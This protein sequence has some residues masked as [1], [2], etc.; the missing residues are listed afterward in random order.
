MS[1]PLPAADSVIFDAGQL[2]IASEDDRVVTGLLLPYGVEGHTNIGGFT[3]DAGMIQLP[4]DPEV[5]TL[6]VEHDREQPVGRAVSIEER[7]DGV[8]ASY[9]IAKTPEGD[10]ALE[11]IRSGKRKSLSMEA[12]GVRVHDGKAIAGRIF[13]SAL[14]ERPAFTGATVIASYADDITDL[15]DGSTLTVGNA[16]TLTTV[17]EDQTPVEPAEGEET[18]PEATVPETVTASAVA[19]VKSDTTKRI[20]ALEAKFDALGKKEEPKGIRPDTAFAAMATVLRGG[21]LPADLHKQVFRGAQDLMEEAATVYAAQTNIADPTGNVDLSPQWAGEFWGRVVPKPRYLQL[22]TPKTLT[23]RTVQGFR[24]TELPSF[25][26][27][28]GN[29][30]EITSGPVTAAATSVYTALKGAGGNTISREEFDFG[31]GA[32]LLA[33]YF[34]KQALNVDMWLDSKVKGAIVEGTIDGGAN[35][36]AGPNAAAAGAVPT[37]VDAGLSYIIDAVFNYMDARDQEVPDYVLVDSTIYRTTV[38]TVTTGVLGYLS[39]ALGLT[40]GELE[41]LAIRPVKTADLTQAKQA[42]GTGGSGTNRTFKAVAGAKAANDIYALPG[43]PFQAQT[44]NVANGLVNVGV[45]AYGLPIPQASYLNANKSDGVY[46]V[47]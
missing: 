30:A 37:G 35:I 22:A 8:Y 46:G 4:T 12:K 40:G 14:V 11:G 47:Y 27:W 3:V 2:V 10:A 45:Y 29:G 41:G 7:A 33:D 42:T 34:G 5:V 13:A 15:P 39:A 26:D 25:G 28:A 20:E 38:K 18:V 23:S 6:N 1:K 31:Q 43:S 17:A 16:T 32:A 21:Q 24:W 9:R 44:V 36:I 19:P